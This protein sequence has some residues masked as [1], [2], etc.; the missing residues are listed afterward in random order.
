VSYAV[1]AG[2]VAIALI[3]LAYWRS[4]FAPAVAFSWYWAVIV[5]ACELMPLGDNALSGTALLVF[6]AGVVAFAGGAFLA[7]LAGRGN[8]AP[9]APKWQTSPGRRRAVHRVVFVYSVLLMALIPTFISAIRAAGA[10]LGIDELSIAAR[11]ALSLADRG[12]VPHYFQSATS[13]G[14]YLAYYA[15]WVYDGTHRSRLALAVAIVA[16]LS[17][18]ALTF[19]RSPIVALMLG[20]LSILVLRRT[21]KPRTVV[22]TFAGTFVLAIVLGAMLNKG[23]EFGT[24]RSPLHAVLENI[25][26]YFVGGPLGFSRVLAD[27]SLVGEA[28][29]SI[30]FFLQIA[31]WLQLSPNI[32]NS[33][34]E[35][36]ITD[37]GNVYTFFFPY[38]FDARF[39]GVLGAGAIAGLVANMV[40]RAARRGLPIAGAA[41][42]LVLGAI[43]TSAVG[44]GLF[45][46][47]MPWLL[48]IVLGVILWHLPTRLPSPGS[49]SGRLPDPAGGG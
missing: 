35:Y 36:I 45:A 24:G 12:G 13:V 2:M 7:E 25:A 33:I 18:S 32:P 27:P 26:V 10:A 15:A 5:L 48:V 20:V 43:F 44:D 1:A 23:P 38:W 47:P 31:Q 14:T 3:S 19:A 40:F 22:L 39:A 41:Y 37:L 8:G 17:M 4:V 28:G 42:G 6:L 9:P 30:R 49:L 11:T 29:L 21:I 16:A 46:S 34:H